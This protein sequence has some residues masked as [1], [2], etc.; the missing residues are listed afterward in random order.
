MVA[1][2]TDT[3]A[4]SVEWATAEL[5]NSPAV[6]KKAQKELSDV[7][8]LNNMVDE[9]HIPKLKYLEAVVKETLR[10]HPTIS[11]LIPRSPSKS[12][13]VGG[14]TIPR[15]TMVYLNVRSIQRDPSI[16][17]SPLEF[18]PE[19]F[20]L[21]DENSKCDFRGNRFHYLPFGSGRRICAGI[22]LAE[23]LLMY[24]LATLLHSFDW[25]IPNGETLDMSEALGTALR[26]ATPLVGIPNP[27]FTC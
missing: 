20:L 5:M 16:W 14:Y 9:L 8:G 23:R 19:R 25:E 2:G 3:T 13:T 26:K 10:L 7:V 21:D 11:L 27:R 15:K 17:D 18:K 24:L 6:M 1:G 12:S 4:I 22:P